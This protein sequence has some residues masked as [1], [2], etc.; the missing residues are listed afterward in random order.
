VEVGTAV[1]VEE[2]AGIVGCL[3]RRSVGAYR[4]RRVAV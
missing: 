3:L 2:L 4:C 1:E